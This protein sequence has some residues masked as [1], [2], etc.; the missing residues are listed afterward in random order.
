MKLGVQTTR[1]PCHPPLAGATA[2]PASAERHLRLR[3]IERRRTGRIVHRRLT[4]RASFP[5]SYL[6]LVARS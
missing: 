5:S 1:T 2:P 4:V 6:D 3:V